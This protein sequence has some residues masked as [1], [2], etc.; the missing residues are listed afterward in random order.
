MM[1]RLLAIGLTCLGLV[2]SP[3]SAQDGWIS[4]FDGKTLE[5]WTKKNGK[6]TY[7]VEDGAIV[8]RTEKKSPNSFLCSDEEFA[9][10]EFGKSVRLIRSGQQKFGQIKEIQVDFNNRTIQVTGVVN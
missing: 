10:F 9:D 8:G 3:G 7:R 4:L 2:A 1:T 6:H 5:G